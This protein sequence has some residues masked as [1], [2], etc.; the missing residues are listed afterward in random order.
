[1]MSRVVTSDTNRPPIRAIGW[2]TLALLV[3]GMAVSATAL[4]HC[5]DAGPPTAPAAVRAAPACA[6]VAT[7]FGRERFLCYRAAAN[8]AGERY[9]LPSPAVG[10]TA[11]A[12][13][14]I[15][16]AVGTGVSRS[17]SATRQ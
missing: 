9:I 3:P 14:G 4:G 10:Q 8:L 17:G 13:S 16:S 12:T 15:G 5:G 7:P 6:T 2:A 1:M 11:D